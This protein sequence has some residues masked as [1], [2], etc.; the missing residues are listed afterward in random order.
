MSPCIMQLRHDGKNS[1]GGTG[2][3]LDILLEPRSLYLMTAEGRYEWAHSI[4]KG[5]QR[6]KDKTVERNRRLSVMFRDAKTV[7]E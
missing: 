2:E 3:I 7:E 4:L 1:Q 5:T 6:F